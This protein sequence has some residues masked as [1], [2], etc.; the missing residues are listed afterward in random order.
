LRAD[1]YIMLILTVAGYIRMG[2][3]YAKRQEEKKEEDSNTQKK[4]TVTEGQAQ[5]EETLNGRSLLSG[6]ILCYHD[7]NGYDIVG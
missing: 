4:E 3:K 7:S 1:F 2:S 5:K 6:R